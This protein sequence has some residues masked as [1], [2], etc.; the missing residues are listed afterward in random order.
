MIA[1]ATEAKNRF[2]YYLSQ[3]EREPVQVFKNDRLAGVLISPA[4]FAQLQ[5]LNPTKT[6]AERQKEFNE[7]YKEWI[8]AQNAMIEKFGIPGED[9]RP[10]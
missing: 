8:D 4:Q 2:G 1:T 5:A 7:T 3:I 10:W 9:L 6:L